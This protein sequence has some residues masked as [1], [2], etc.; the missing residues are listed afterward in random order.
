MSDNLSAS[1]SETTFTVTP[2]DNLSRGTNYKIKI[3]TTA[4]D[5][6]NNSLADNYTTSNGFTTYGTGTIR[7]TVRYDNNTAADNVSVGFALSGTIVDNKTTN[8]SGDYSQDNLSLGTYTLTYTKS[9]FSDTNLSATLATD[10]QTVTANVTLLASTCSRETQ[11]SSLRNPVG[12]SL[13]LHV[14][15][16]FAVTS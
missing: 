3:T 14:N 8:T 15:H 4:A 5:T 12:G 16:S 13:E 10:N 1:N 6:S 7:G 11:A 2:E 9:G